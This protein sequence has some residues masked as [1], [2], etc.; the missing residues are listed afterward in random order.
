MP[1]L[2]ERDEDDPEQT[3]TDSSERQGSF[4]LSSDIDEDKHKSKSESDFLNPF[5]KWKHT[6]VEFC[7]INVSWTNA[8]S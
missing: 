5:L 2:V 1:Q 3:V 4:E 7:Q 8:G 6:I